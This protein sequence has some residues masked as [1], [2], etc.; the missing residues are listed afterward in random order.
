MNLYAILKQLIGPLTWL[1]KNLQH[2]FPPPAYEQDPRTLPMN[3][4]TPKQVDTPPTA[5]PAM[6]PARIGTTPSYDWS[7]VASARHSVRVICDEEGVSSAKNILIDDAYYSEKDTLCATIGEESGWQSYYLSGPKKGEPVQRFNRSKDGRI[8]LSTD[9]G[10][11]Q[12]NSYWHWVRSGEI[13]PDEALNNPEKSVRLM[14]AYWKQGKQHEWVAYDT[15]A[16]KKH[17]A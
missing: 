3:Q 12:W 4:E 13:S 7:T 1:E 11:C 8:V 15:G 16:Y 14:C 17:L 9:N 5:A 10:I 2:I 6:S